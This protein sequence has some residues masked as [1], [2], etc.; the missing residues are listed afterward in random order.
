MSLQVD[1]CKVFNW[2]PENHSDVNQFT[3]AIFHKLFSIIVIKNSLYSSHE[4]ISQHRIK[5]CL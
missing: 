4:D 2:R 5:L 1:N 3:A